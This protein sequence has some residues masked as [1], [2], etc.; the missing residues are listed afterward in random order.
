MVVPRGGRYWLG[1]EE[2]SGTPHLGPLESELNAGVVA[3]GAVPYR[4]VVVAHPVR[5]VQALKNNAV[6]FKVRNRGCCK[7]AVPIH[8]FRSVASVVPVV[9][10]QR[11]Q[12]RWRG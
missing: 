11:R 2:W 8:A 12:W 1:P 3:V 7:R 5:F 4:C 9:R 10:R 6:A